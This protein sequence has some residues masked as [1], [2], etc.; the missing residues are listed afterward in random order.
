M[1]Y[2]VF[3]LEWNQS[4]TG[5]EKEIDRLPFE[6]IEI[7]AVKLNNKREITGKYNQLIK[8]KVYREMHYVTQKL[9]HLEMDELET[10]KSF[11]EAATEFL[12]WCGKDCL[13]CSWGPLDLT[14]FQKNTLKFI[15]NLL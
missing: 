13:F 14:E 11:P 6:I 2:I 8:P 10:G 15:N 7:G 9:I 3:D 4:N 1:D 12:E 5:K